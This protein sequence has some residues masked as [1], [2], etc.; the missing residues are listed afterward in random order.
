[1]DRRIALKNMG[2]AFGYTVATPTLIGLMQSCQDEK[3]L[4]W[5]PSFFTKDQALAL[6]QLVDIILPKTDTPSASEVNVD[7]FIDRFANE[8][9]DEETQGFMLMAFDVFNNNALT[10][11]GKEEVADL[12]TEDLEAALAKALKV[13]TEEQKLND[14]IIEKYIEAKKKGENIDLNENIANSAFATN[15]RNM[16][17]WA[18]KTS[19]YIGEEVLAYLPV[20]GEYIPCGDLEELT[21]GKAWSI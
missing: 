8:V 19:E 1:M 17:I 13:S 14:E 7:V 21:G 20:P 3:S 15:L 16:T 5:T 11:S 2:L 18:Y 9:M 10:S 12:S 6:T 4:N